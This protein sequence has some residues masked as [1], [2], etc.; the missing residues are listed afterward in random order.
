MIAHIVPSHC[1]KA[2]GQRWLS[3]K[4]LGPVSWAA[5]VLALPLLAASTPLTRYSQR[6]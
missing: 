4:L 1:V 3:R 2:S 5:R 6:N